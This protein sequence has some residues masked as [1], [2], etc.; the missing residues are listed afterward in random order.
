MKLGIPTNI[1][2]PKLRLIPTVIASLFIG[3][4]FIFMLQY[5]YPTAPG[6]C[7]KIKEVSPMATNSYQPFLSYDLAIANP[8]MVFPTVMDNYDFSVL[9]DIEVAYYNTLTDLMRKQRKSNQEGPITDS[10][11]FLFP[12]LAKSEISKERERNPKG[13]GRHP[14]N[15]LALFKSFTGARYLSMDVNSR[16]VCMLLNSNPAFFERV[17]FPDNRIPSYRVIDRFDQVMTESNL[18]EKAARIIIQKNIDNK[19]INPRVEDKLII[20]TTHIPARAKRGKLIK[21]CR[22]CRAKD[23]C[24]YKIT[25]DD[26]AGI[27]I[28]SKTEIYFAHKI[29]LSSLTVSKLPIDWVVDR[30]ETYDGHFFCPLLQSFVDKFPMFTISKVIADGIFNYKDNYLCAQKYLKAQ[31]IAPIN[32]RKC[33]EIL[34][35][36]RGIKKIT[37]Q[38]Q[39]ICIDDKP[40]FLITKNEPT[41]EY[42]WGCSVYHP[43][44]PE[45]DLQYICPMRSQCNNTTIGRVY[46]TKA[47][48]FPQ[49]C[50]D[51][52]QFSKIA[53]SIFALRTTIER[54]I[55]QL[56]EAL[57]MESLWKR[58]KDNVNAHVAKCLIAMHMV[59]WIAHKTHNGDLMHS[60]KTFHLQ[61]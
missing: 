45:Y 11:G 33:K 6:F 13:A 49:I 20:D 38:G 3:F 57:K 54:E 50:W 19:I 59:A 35:P 31:L 46:R 52:P 14:K 16:S 32:S 40:M 9:S 7:R 60:I 2:L 42:I 55:G 1:K 29:G 37:K 30:G 43:E 26:N 47:D 25:T 4:I 23:I 27:L 21:A 22:K 24:P 10:Q 61:K 41:R 15:F 39:P 18:W 17:S 48:E 5:F 12:E 28:K 34:N 56:K 8:A 44:S 53:K 58:G 36:A 51:F